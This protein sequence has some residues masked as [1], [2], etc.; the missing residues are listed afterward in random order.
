MLRGRARGMD[1][2]RLGSDVKGVLLGCFVRRLLRHWR[3]KQL[4]MFAEYDLAVSVTL[5]PPRL[6]MLVAVSLEL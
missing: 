1:V 3:R 2:A 6:A 5:R 4:P